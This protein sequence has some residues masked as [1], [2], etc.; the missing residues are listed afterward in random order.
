MKRRNTRRNLRK[1]TKRNLRKNSR[2]NTRKNLRKNLRGGAELTRRS[3]RLPLS[4]WGDHER[5]ATQ[6]EI[7]LL[8][9]AKKKESALKEE[10]AKMKKMLLDLVEQGEEQ[11]RAPAQERALAQE[12]GQGQERAQAR[13]RARQ[14][15]AGNRVRAMK[16][17]ID[18][19]EKLRDM[20]LFDR[21]AK[22]RAADLDPRVHPELQHKLMDD[23][24]LDNLKRDYQK[25]M[26]YFNELMPDGRQ[27]GFL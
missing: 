20:N 21:K 12:K 16:A 14:N 7:D 26:Q 22:M 1:N 24:L 4:T 15:A 18:R 2:K 9:E 25:R 19:Q 27:R 3:A 17:E 6:A 5:Q 13:E 10:I 23:N 8:E 11:E